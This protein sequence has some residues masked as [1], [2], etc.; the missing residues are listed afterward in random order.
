MLSLGGGLAVVVIALGSHTFFDISESSTFCGTVCHKPMYPEYTT[1]Q[2]SPHSNVQ[3]SSCHVGPG[4][5]N[6]IASKI[7]GIPQ[8]TETLSGNYPKP[9]PAPVNN[10]R[11]VMDTCLKC[12]APQK[13]S[14]DFVKTVVTYK[15][16]AT[17]TQESYSLVLK[18]GGG[19]SNTTAGIHWHITSKVWYLPMDDQHYSIG[20]VGVETPGG[21]MDEY[22]NP[23]Y[24]GTIT[25]E[26]IQKDKRQMDCIECHNR[27]THVFSSPSDLIDKAIR[28]GSIDQN[29][30]FIKAKGLQALDPQNPSLEI[31]NAKVEA[32]D[33]YY[34]TTYPA[35]YTS[36]KDRI[37]KAISKLKEIAKLTTFPDNNVNWDTYPDFSGHNKPADSVL[38]GVD[39]KFDNWKN[40]PSQGCFRCHGTLVPATKNPTAVKMGLGATSTYAML[41]ASSVA[42]NTTAIIAPSVGDNL[43]TTSRTITQ[44]NGDNL[45]ASAESP[46]LK[47][48]IDI[49][50]NVCHYS[51]ANTSKSPVPKDVIHPTE[52]LSDCMVCHGKTGPKPIP[53]DHPWSTNEA[54]V[55]CHKVAP[56]TL[57][58]TKPSQL[59]KK[60][61]PHAIKGLEDCLLCHSTSSAKPIKADHP[62]ATNDT[63]RRV[64]CFRRIQSRSRR[65]TSLLVPL[66]AYPIPRWG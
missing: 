62:W 12:H 9:I 44:T 10:L 47:D 64:I 22:V 50:C 25:P 40:D 34:R 58:A 20:W 6:M 33:G 8:I 16:D 52:K 66:S 17:N 60:Q 23:K 32:I 55:A 65:R 31:A 27:V 28:D 42:D 13:F 35:I 45:T 36:A 51:P 43:T 19:S 4:T 29:L 48:T 61:I 3:C 5:L 63:S 14:G 46:K 24:V 57:P 26:L 38:T 37:A 18:V 53:A 7:R 56:G 39:I 49:G 1:Y 11:P 30:P 2:Q 59:S 54:C 15:P 21:G 41:L